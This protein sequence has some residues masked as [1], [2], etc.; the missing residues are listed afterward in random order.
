MAQLDDYVEYLST[1]VGPRPAGT[2][3]EQQ[4]ALYISDKLKTDAGLQVSIE[5]FASSSNVFNV[6]AICSAIAFISALFFVIVPAAGILWLVLGVAAAVVYVLESLDNPV[7]TRALARGVSQNIVAK[8]KPQTSDASSRSRKIILMAHYDT[9]RSVP[10]I[11][12]TIE[13]TNLPLAWI[14]LGGVVAVP[15]LELIRLVAPTAASVLNVLLIIAGIVAVLPFVREILVRVSPFSEGANCNASGTAALME[16]ARCVGTGSLTSDEFAEAE[17]DYVVHDETTALEN[18][19]VPEGAEIVYEVQETTDEPEDRPQKSE[20]ERLASAKAAIAAFTG[21]PGAEWS[22]DEIEENLQGTEYSPVKKKTVVV[23]KVVA[24]PDAPEDNAAGASE[25]ADDQVRVVDLT[26]NEAVADV[27]SAPDT[28]QEAASGSDDVASIAAGTSAPSA[29]ASAGVNQPARAEAAERPAR[30]MAQGNAPQEK[31]A[32]APAAMTAGDST[33]PTASAVQVSSA[34]VRSQRATEPENSNVPSWYLEAQKKARRPKQE[35]KPVQRSRFASALEAAEN[36]GGNVFHEEAQKAY[37]ERL[38]A[39]MRE[40]RA[41]MAQAQVQGQEQQRAAAENQL[42]AD[43]GAVRQ[44]APAGQAASVAEP[45]Q[46]AS[47]VE[48]VSIV[49][50]SRQAAET[51]TGQPAAT[52]DEPAQAAAPNLPFAQFTAPVLQKD[53]PA[54]SAPVNSTAQA[55][56]SGGATS[57]QGGRTGETSVRESGSAHS[58]ASVPSDQRATEAA[59]APQPSPQPQAS[60]PAASTSEWADAAD[61]NAYAKTPDTQAGSPAS[62]LSLGNESNDRAASSS[63]ARA[64]D[65]PAQPTAQ[66]DQQAGQGI[67]APMQTPDSGRVEIEHPS[68]DYLAGEY[69]EMPET[70][71][72]QEFEQAFAE[73]DVSVPSF[74]DPWKTQERAQ[75]EASATARSANRY[76]VTPAA[77]SDERVA[78]EVEF[79]DDAPAPARSDAEGQVIDEQPVSA[80]SEAADE[81]AASEQAR[82]VSGA[83]A[84]SKCAYDDDPYAVPAFD[85]GTTGVEFAEPSPAQSDAAAAPREAASQSTKASSAEMPSARPSAACVSSTQGVHEPVAMETAHQAPAAGSFDDGDQLI[86]DG[87]HAVH[88]SDSVPHRRRTI[89]LPHV[90]MTGRLPFASHSKQRAPLADAGEKGGKSA[91]KGLLSTLPSIDMDNGAATKDSSRSGVLRSL[92]DH[93]PSTTAG[94]AD[95]AADSGKSGSQ[96]AVSSVGS[97]G[98]AGATGAFAPVGDEL[99]DDVSP[100]EIYVDDAD[101]SDLDENYTESGAFAGPGY[102]D[103]PKSHFR[104]FFSRFHRKAE[105]DDDEQSPQEWLDVDEE[106]DPREEGRK[107]GGW[108]SFN[109]ESNGHGTDGS[110]DQQSHRSTESDG[111]DDVANGSNPAAASNGAASSAM[112]NDQEF[113]PID[114]NGMDVWDQDGQNG[115]T[116][117][118]ATGTAYGAGAYGSESYV[119]G[120]YS[121]EVYGE[122]HV[123][124]A[125]EFGSARPEVKPGDTSPFLPAIQKQGGKRRHHRRNRKDSSWQGGGFSTDRATEEGA[126]YDEAAEAAAVDDEVERI[127]QFKE[128]P[129][130]TEVWFVALGSEQDYHDGV[131]QFATA[132]ADDLRG[133]VV[134]DIESLGR[135]KLSLPQQ[136]GKLRTKKISARMKRFAKKASSESGVPIAMKDALR[137]ESAASILS[138]QGVQAMHVVGVDGNV[139]ASKGDAADLYENLDLNQLQDNVSLILALLKQI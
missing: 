7:I 16:S 33:V 22:E 72:F 44:A 97:F 21:Q 13:G 117:D 130:G 106:F 112:A 17:Q 122:E 28:G 116:Y 96:T 114:T 50:A 51:P 92:K 83:A 30:A 48:T 123:T 121:D 66:S 139:V 113:Q 5:E 24:A 82:N 61:R 85:A 56:S 105:T 9:G 26:T 124:E 29:D 78:I 23:R 35:T 108:E 115:T 68:S 43:D 46:T 59:A 111:Q 19:V 32:G 131:R 99:L 69:D 12:R 94:D 104:N 127:Y 134:I 110:A 107:R 65:A 98:A 125:G 27:E 62:G 89:A 11:V 81:F 90:G 57:P 79:H 18:G 45:S 73:K 40:D 128:D 103:M 55:A 70:A 3:E 118:Y 63:I 2:E 80:E 49:D 77:A 86:D 76:E 136:E 120:V 119:S 71:S 14:C 52:A 126:P 58:V 129:F 100:D 88:A 34:P 25:A 42:G 47:A 53:E 102:V 37:E 84:E 87:V 31:A 41:A 138:R 91:A 4:A 8:Y 38:A 132:H 10:G 36:R 135:G 15:V 137:D 95:G 93:L 6:K 101:D 67:V 74:M 54:Q 133:A 39:Q 20:G 60:V 109:E 64:Q 75:Q 1:E